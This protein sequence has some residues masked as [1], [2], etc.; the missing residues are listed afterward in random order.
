M[1]FDPDKEETLTYR[2]N[3]DLIIRYWTHE[4]KLDVLIGKSIPISEVV[5]ELKHFQFLDR[6][7]VKSSVYYYEYYGRQIPM[8]A[9]HYTYDETKRDAVRK[10]LYDNYKCA[11]MK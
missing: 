8:T 1:S 10:F 5:A 2:L 9:H 7:Q 4:A 3:E 11:D 6:P